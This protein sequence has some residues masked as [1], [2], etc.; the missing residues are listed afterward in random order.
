MTCASI[1][2][3]RNFVPNAGRRIHQRTRQVCLFSVWLQRPP[4]DWGAVLAEAE[5]MLAIASIAQRFQIRPLSNAGVTPIAAHDAAPRR[6][7][8]EGKGASTC[9]TSRQH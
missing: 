2:I 3:L 4:I 5:A 6:R 9:V 7:K 8:C 1:L